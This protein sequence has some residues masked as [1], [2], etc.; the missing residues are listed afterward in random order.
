MALETYF[1]TAAA[2]RSPMFDRLRK[3]VSFER[4]L[5]R[6]QVARD[7]RWLL[8]GGFAMQLRVGE[9]AR[10]TR[11]LDVG[12][13]LAM[14]GKTPPSAQEVR[15]QLAR[16]AAQDEGDYF[17]FSVAESRDIA[18]EA[19]EVLAF[20]FPIKGFL[21]GRLFESFHIDVGLGDSLVAP[22]VDLHGSD[23]LG[24]AEIPRP[25]F[26]ATTIQQHF[27]E[28]IHALTR[29]WENRENTRVRDL[30]DLMLLLDHGL[31]DAEEARHAIQA[32]FDARNSHAVPPELPDVPGSWEPLYAKQ[33]REQELGQENV[34]AAMMRLR[35]YWK[36]L[37]WHGK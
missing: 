16:A 18:P 37:E 7:D 22:P 6:L 34:G 1:K 23:L 15:K 31:P 2:G 12:A 28:K 19:E 9:K 26:R 33:A 13:N 5:V 3:L 30:V 32:V 4:Y 20:R 21:D 35:N 25:V 24:F 11:D 17:E 10:G 29:E 14:F 27:A 8:K 36:E